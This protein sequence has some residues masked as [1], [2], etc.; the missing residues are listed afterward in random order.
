MLNPCC[1][2][3]PTA[4]PLALQSQ[5]QATKGTVNTEE[6]MAAALAST[7][8]GG[9]VS[10]APC[11]NLLGMH[12]L[13]GGPA[14]APRLRQAQT[15]AAQHWQQVW[16]RGAKG[17]AGHGRDSRAGKGGCRLAGWVPAGPAGV[18]GPRKAAPSLPPR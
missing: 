6:M 5:C 2:L 9:W 14:A 8:A 11:A 12:Q 17:K 7:R 18:C 1:R 16:A 10:P 4:C 13:N 3:T 15:Q